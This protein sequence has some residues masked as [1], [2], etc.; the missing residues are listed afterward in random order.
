MLN[1]NIL[2]D[3]EWLVYINHFKNREKQGGNT[4]ELLRK[5]KMSSDFQTLYSLMLKIL[6]EIGKQ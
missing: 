4:D 6:R 3:F 2:S 5:K 1:F